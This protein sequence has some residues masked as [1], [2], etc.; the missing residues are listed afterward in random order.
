MTGG[1][2]AGMSG[3]R[4][5]M[6]AIAARS[7][8]WRALDRGYQ[9]SRAT[10]LG[11][12]P[13]RAR[14]ALLVLVALAATDGSSASGSPT[15]PPG[16]I[17]RAAIACELNVARAQAGLPPVRA[18]PAL[19]RAATA[20][21]EDMVARGYFAHETPAGTGPAERARRAGYLDGA[22]RWRIGEVLIWSRG[23]PLTAEAAVTAW[24]GSPDHRRIL[25]RRAFRDIGVGI[26]A[27]APFGSADAQP[28]TTIAVSF[29]RRAIKPALRRAP[30]R[31]STEPA[32]TAARGRTGTAPP[33]RAA[34]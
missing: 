32:G 11:H 26:A 28:A 19:E 15:C 2:H 27:G 5:D 17:D 30:L 33:A 25:L 21:A 34:C 9:S 22:V 20:H 13:P 3:S 29:G 1:S 18:R 4:G 7:S 8:C 14:L 6:P 12:I 23:T 24:L 16:G 31:T 10:V